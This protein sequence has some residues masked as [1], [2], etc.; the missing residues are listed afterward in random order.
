MAWGSQIS[1][2]QIYKVIIS[3]LLFFSYFSTRIQIVV[4]KMLQFS[5]TI[6]YLV[7]SIKSCCSC[8]PLLYYNHWP[9]SKFRDH[10]MKL[11]SRINMA[12]RFEDTEHKEPLCPNLSRQSGR[13]TK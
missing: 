8:F 13:Y 11:L 3:L 5:Y 9:V 4:R 12:L 1:T 6:N 7:N 10:S 2:S